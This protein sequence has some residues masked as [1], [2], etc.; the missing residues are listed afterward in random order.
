[1]SD[2]KVGDKVAVKQTD[3]GYIVVNAAGAEKYFGVKDGINGWSIV[4]VVADEPMIGAGK[5]GPHGTA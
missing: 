1:M 5:G 4:E 2:W 3:N